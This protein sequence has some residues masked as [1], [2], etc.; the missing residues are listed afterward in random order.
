M[1]TPRPP[2][3]P[4]IPLGLALLLL[5]I[6]AAIPA[7]R[8]SVHAAE[9]PVTWR[10]QVAPLLYANCTSCHHTG[11]SGPFDLTTFAAAKRWGSSIQ[12]VTAS[13]YM[14]PWLPAPGSVDFPNNFK[15]SRR[16]TD[17]QI[18]LVHS[19]IQAGM[20]EG[21]GSAPPPPTYAKD[22]QLGP[23]DLILEMSSP[24]QVPADGPDLFENFALPTSITSTLWI[25]AMEIQPGSPILVHHAN[26]ILDRTASLRHAHPTD[27]PSG[28]PGMDILVD[29]GDTF[30]PDS[31]FLFWKPDSTALV[32]PAS[33]PWRL[34]PG[35]DL[36]LN[37]HLKPT[38]KT[39]T[40]RARI[41]L[42]VTPK[43]AT[44]LPMLLQLEDDNALDIPANTPD[45]VVQDQLTLPIAVDVLGVYPHAHYLGKRL[46]GW[47]D[48][49]DGSRRGLILIPDWDIDR[50]SV[51]RLREPLYLPQ[52]SVLHMRYTYD[53]SAANPRNPNSPPI[54]VRAGNR[55]VDEMGHLWLQVLP[56]PN[57]TDTS[58]A[59]DPRQILDR[60]WMQNRLRK[61]PGDKVA[62]YNLASLSMMEND[63]AAAIP[64]Y[65]RVLSQQPSDL[66][67]LTSLASA[68]A[69]TGDWASA[70]TRFR[71]IL[72]AD[73]TFADA[74]FDLASIDL[75]HDDP[76]EA[77]Q[78]LE[79]FT[80]AHTKD[81][82]AQRLL[83]VSI[84]ETGSPQDALPA[85]KAWQELQPS[86]ADPHRALAQVYAQLD[87]S[88]DA[89]REQQLVLSLDPSSA[90]DWN[91][92]AMLQA[93]SG[94]FSAARQSLLHA[95]T[96]DPSNTTFRNNLA[97]IP[98][99]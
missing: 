31:H 92:L 13:R 42:Y 57:P 51:Y 87:R 93:H 72:A 49:P 80:R 30:D 10:N 4:L 75:Q 19:W 69:A 45:F 47:A 50:Q 35:N 89:L 11:G 36:I 37:M 94:N 41:G 91:D 22:W 70:Q 90:A 84:A 14:P 38:G 21:E 9:Q 28:I 68:I 46:E 23:P 15:D 26:V 62:L 44:S 56:H 58:P 54:P 27:W 66:R 6:L 55:S 99:P 73:P 82:E 43:P 48:L 53:N 60:A 3:L 79:M 52:G 88:S 8:R 5:L 20:P 67:A 61:D 78:L 2:H 59:Q 1:T 96:L 74:Q 95:L 40:V 77:R 63:P 98:Q 71:S 86:A 85:L 32:E 34:D 83:A 12:T 81:P 29:S 17:D 33:M 64:L 39:E 25:R 7:H 97:R 65:Q 16:L 76:A 18:A 24:L